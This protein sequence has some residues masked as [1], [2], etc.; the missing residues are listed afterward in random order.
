MRPRSSSRLDFP[1]F[2]MSDSKFHRQFIPWDRQNSFF[3]V[4]QTDRSVLRTLVRPS[5]SSWFKLVRAFFWKSTGI[6]VPSSVEETL[7][8]S[9]DE[10][11]LPLDSPVFSAVL[12]RPLL[13]WRVSAGAGTEQPPRSK[14]DE[15]GG[16][17]ILSQPNKARRKV[18]RRT[19]PAWLHVLRR[20]LY[21]IRSI[22]L[23]PTLPIASLL[24][25]SWRECIFLRSRCNNLCEAR[26]VFTKRFNSGTASVEFWEGYWKYS[27]LI[28]IHW[29][30]ASAGGNWW[31]ANC[32]VFSN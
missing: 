28:G 2:P 16:E 13:L 15:Q 31:M 4:A 14:D 23:I 25:R 22:R 17:K 30:P 32:D 6:H 5:S 10:F 11:L 7:T 27:N 18:T 9:T 19:L 8:L 1:Q 3:Q 24:F 12:T 26:G 29:N 20:F 21:E